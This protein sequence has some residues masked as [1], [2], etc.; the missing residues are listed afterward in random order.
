MNNPLGIHIIYCEFENSQ[1]DLSNIIDEFIEIRKVKNDV[2]LTLCINRKET[3]TTYDNIEGITI[4]NSLSYNKVCNLISKHTIGIS[5]DNN[6]IYEYNNYNL[7]ICDNINFLRSIKYTNV[8]VI[9]D[10]FSYLSMK[11]LNGVNIYQISNDNIFDTFKKQY[12][13]YFWCE[14]AWGGLHG[15]WAGKI[16]HNPKKLNCDELKDVFSILEYCKKHNK[17]TFFCNKED[18]PHYNANRRGFNALALHFDEIYTTSTECVKKYKTH[19]NKDVKIYNFNVNLKLFNPIN[20]NN[21]DETITFFGAWYKYF[22]QRCNQMKKILDSINNA[23]Y[24]LQIYDRNYSKNS[25]N[26]KFPIEYQKYTTNAVPMSDI[27]SILKKHKYSLTLN[28]V[29]TDETMFARRIHEINL[30]NVLGISNYSKGIH[31]IFK[32]TVF[33]VDNINEF[34]K[35]DKLNKNEYELYKL[36]NLNIS[37]AYSSNNIHSKIFDV[38]PDRNVTKYLYKNDKN[39]YKFHEFEFINSISDVSTNSS[40]TFLSKY[41]QNNLLIERYLNHF[42][43]L[44]DKYAI[45]IQKGS[46]KNYTFDEEHT[47]NLENGYIF[48]QSYKLNETIPVYIIPDANLFNVVISN[49]NALENFNKSIEKLD[50]IQMDKL[51]YNVL[52]V[53]SCPVDT[54]NIPV[55]NKIILQNNDLITDQY[56]SKPLITIPFDKLNPC[57]INVTM[58]SKHYSYISEVKYDFD[59][60]ARNDNEI[61]LVY[62]GTLRDEENTLEIIEEFQKIHKERPEVVLKIVYGKIVGDIDFKD[63]VNAY[64]KNGVNGIT[65]KHNLNYKDACYEIATSD[66]GICWRKNGWGDNGEISTKVKEYELYGIGVIGDMKLKVGVVTSTNKLNKLENIIRNFKQQK[67]INKKLFVI[68]NN[69]NIQFDKYKNNLEKENINYELIKVDEKFN[70]GYCLNVGINLMKKQNIEIFSKFDDDDIYL[71]NYLLEQVSYLNKYNNCIIGKYNIP[72]F[73]PEYNNFYTIRNFTKNNMFTKI[74]RGS[75]IMF[76][77]NNVTHRF[78]IHKR[79]GTDTIFLKEHLKNNGKIYV[80]SFENYIWIRYLD[81]KK[82]TWDLDIHKFPL[83]K[84]N[85]C[86]L[87]YNLYSNLLYYELINVSGLLV[88]IIITMYNSSKTIEK[89]L[90]SMIKQTHKNL[91]IVVVDDQSTD[92]SVEI[93][94]RVIKKYNKI[95]LIKNKENKG[96]YYCK[97]LALKTLNK[98]T[99]YIAFQDSDDYSHKERIRKQIEI[100]Y[101]TNGK[102]SVS[103]C[104]R[105]N[106]LRF[107]C[108]SQVYDIEIFEKLGYFDNSRFGADSLQIQ[109]ILNYYEKSKILGSYIYEKI[110]K[111]FQKF[112]KSFLIPH[113]LYI[114]NSNDENCLTNVN[115]LHS[116]KR[117]IYS[118]WIQEFYNY[119]KLLQNTSLINYIPIN[120]EIEYT[121]NSIN[122]IITVKKEN[123]KILNSVLIIFELNSINKDME[124]FVNIYEDNIFKNKLNIYQENNECYSYILIDNPNKILSFDIHIDNYKNVKKIKLKNIDYIYYYN[125]ITNKF[126]LNDFPYKDNNL[127]L[128]N[129]QIKAFKFLTLKYDKYFLNSGVGPVKK[130]DTDIIDIPNL[131]LKILGENPLVSIIITCYNAENTIEMA[132]NSLL[133]QTYK[134]IEIIIVDD[135]SHDKSRNIINKFKDK[136]NVKIIFNEKNNETYSSRNVA[137]QY[138]SGDFI[139]FQDA[140]D[141]SLYDRIEKQVTYSIKNKC[142]INIGL[143]LRTNILNKLNLNETK[144]SMFDKIINNIDTSKFNNFSCFKNKFIL[145]L[146]KIPH[147]GLVTSF[148]HKSVFNDIGNFAILPCSGDIEFI[149]RF[150]CKKYNLIFNE[151]P[152]GNLSTLLT[153]VKNIGSV[154]IMKETIYIAQH[155][156]TN[157]TSKYNKKFRSELKQSYRKEY[158]KDNKNIKHIT[159]SE[160]LLI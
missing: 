123:F 40:Y 71:E 54:R 80:T 8:A 122:N 86:N 48:P 140:D 28:S 64:I 47:I 52:F 50:G 61:R 62:C 111:I 98:K 101:L 153:N 90:E 66:I 106:N 160:N 43:Y 141:I 132:I 13:K 145:P 69:N 107:A 97:N 150:L 128:K 27:C 131:E 94:E 95:R 10:D 16:Y 159:L 87:V 158:E 109:R 139:T 17:K 44:E 25:V 156:D 41:P 120:Y 14:S 67:Y 73:I 119:E 137:L 70:L 113:C 5:F 133:N 26:H 20:S 33:L 58:L 81:K 78:D 37:L 135:C 114:I 102:L 32:D 76:N 30:S 149:E 148:I 46:N 7:E 142:H 39:Q 3:C 56:F 100:L 9:L 84:I 154:H 36:I 99:K 82:H 147:L 143:C 11:E 2:F 127:K 136:D 89:C 24:S 18:P 31:N 12:I 57:D 74:C 112:K 49:Y 126:F 42:D 72:I 92:N 105:Y 103:L 152:F 117:Y 157:L 79:Q 77:L 63:K 45:C 104:K 60:P 1:V 38:I 4:Y 59:L 121:I 21:N 51:F 155:S 125:N 151:S 91:D 124:I 138:C 116:N 6:F 96:T 35:F 15:K 115:K 34:E 19:Y 68:I 85:D 65:F 22:P 110:L 144:S 55:E 118:N 88:T 146:S 134:N 83:K 130:L 23:K 108:I 29:Q 53:D 93:V 75:T 129:E